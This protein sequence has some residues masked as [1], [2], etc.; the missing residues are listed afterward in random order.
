MDLRIDAKFLGTS[1]EQ[2]ITERAQTVIQQE[3]SPVTPQFLIYDHEFTA[4]VNQGDLVALPVEITTNMRVLSVILMF[5][6]DIPLTPAEYGSANVGNWD[7]GTTVSENTQFFGSLS[8]GVAMQT[9]R[10][11][12]LYTGC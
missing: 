9:F 6:T 3:V 5:D 11:V 2:K 7:V 1:V 12:V 10:T 8:M 4:E